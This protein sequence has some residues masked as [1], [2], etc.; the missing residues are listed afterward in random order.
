MNETTI[1]EIRR[2]KDQAEA[3]ILQELQ[4]L[5]EKSGQMEVFDVSVKY[6]DATSLDSSRR[7]TMIAS[8]RID[9][10]VP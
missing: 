8:V 10:R 3:R 2:A 9:L 1:G 7:R 6:V 4:Q 5:Q